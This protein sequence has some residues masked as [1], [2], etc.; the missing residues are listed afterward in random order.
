MFK[1]QILVPVLEN[2]RKFPDTNAFCIDGKYFTYGE[3]GK[4]IGKIRA[5]LCNR[6]IENRNVGLVTN[7]DLE[8]YASIFALWLDGY[9]YVP[10]HIKQPIDRCTNIIAQVGIDTI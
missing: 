7:N 3:F 10:L 9:C 5:M 4:C 8:T 2:I 6:A 1:E